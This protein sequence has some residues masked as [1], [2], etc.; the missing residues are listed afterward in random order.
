MK[1]KISGS[2]KLKGEVRKFNI[3][4]EANSE[5]HLKDKV[6]AYFGS[7]YGAKRNSVEISEI[8]GA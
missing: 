2:V 1:Y 5:A 6:Y 3:D 7:K 8:K 4:L